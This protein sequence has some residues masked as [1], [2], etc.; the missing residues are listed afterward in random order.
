MKHMDSLAH[1]DGAIM[2]MAAAWVPL[3]VLMAILVVDVG[4]WFEH[5]RHLQLQ[6]DAGAFAAAQEFGV[7]DPDLGCGAA[8]NAAID[9]RARQ[10]GGIEGTPVYNAQIGGTPPDQVR[11]LLN[12]ETYYN[13]PDRTDP[14]ADFTGLGPCADGMI[15]VKL[16]ETDLP[17]YF[18]V[19][20]VPFINAHARVSIFQQSQTE[21]A[22]PVGVP[23]PRPKR[24]RV[25]FIDEVTGA[26]LASS[27]LV[28]GGTSGGLVV[29]SNED[30]PAPVQI[31]SAHVGVRVILSGSSTNIACGEPL[32][33]CYDS[34]S[35]DGLLHIGGWSATSGA[36][37][38]RDVTLLN[39]TCSDPYFSYSSDTCT[40]GVRAKF[41]F[42]ADPATVGGELDALVGNKRVALSYDSATDTWTSP[43]T[44]D[45]AS[46]AGPV[47]IGLEWR[48]TQGCTETCSG[49]I[50]NVQRAFAGTDDRSG[51]I[52]L[53]QVEENGAL[54]ANSF[55]R[56]A[57][58]S[59]LHNLVVRIGVQGSLEN[60]RDV[61]DPVVSLRVVGG[62]QNQSLDCDPA[63][64]NLRDEIAG[65][66]SPAYEVNDG[67]ACP[68][69]TEPFDC[70]PLQTGTQ[71]NQVAAGMNLRVYGDEKATVCT[72][73][74]N[75]SL[76]PDIPLGDP[77]IVQVFL[78][79][80]GTFQGSGNASIPVTGFATFYAT[81]WSGQ[82]QGFKNPCEGLGD[83][84]VPNGEGGYLVGH[85]IK[86]VQTLNNG[87]GTAPCD[88]GGF[89]SCVAVLTE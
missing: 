45:V 61:N 9:Q 12:S 76:F 43:A 74:N 25:Q 73:P 26:V 30:A 66:C 39:G 79:P 10:Y 58:D 86:Y 52:R 83:D 60:A 65:G 14:T 46:A 81:G 17:W 67:T 36:P 44:I 34:G 24:A 27:D 11:L 49:T 19:A 3:M 16:T 82:G 53:A 70:V 63:V 2:V 50:S 41:D 21:G 8:A 64:A 47:W 4:N 69:A 22:L 35:T 7:V 72:K 68:D 51:P 32:V 20:Q 71:R 33:E 42:G 78:T 38:A 85:F 1:Q 59:C 57:T 84:P 6:A 55:E 15:D 31:D 56:C 62:S 37:A 88:F 87:G 77:R 80:F 23:D 54:W 75:W 29:W 18:R 5:K 89:G 48:K 40:I 13:Q 28:R